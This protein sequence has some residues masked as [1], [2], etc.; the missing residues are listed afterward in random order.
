MNTAKRV[1][2]QA[3]KH[4]IPYGLTASGEPWLPTSP[5]SVVLVYAPVDAMNMVA[6]NLVT[7]E[8]AVVDNRGMKH[9][10]NHMVLAWV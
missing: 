1:Q 3:H 8:R 10:S 7:K 2:P 5:S 4:M 9:I 6:M